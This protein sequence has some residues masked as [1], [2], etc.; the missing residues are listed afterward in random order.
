[1]MMIIIINSSNGGD[2][3]KNIFVSGSNAPPAQFA[4]PMVEGAINVA[5]GRGQRLTIGGVN[6]G[7]IL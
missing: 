3:M 7:P 1:M 2:G 6:S 4:P 5:S